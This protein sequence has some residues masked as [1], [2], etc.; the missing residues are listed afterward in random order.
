MEVTV[1]VVV[2]AEVEVKMIAAVIEV[3]AVDRFE[4]AVVK[5]RALKSNKNNKN[6]LITKEMKKKIKLIRNIRTKRSQKT[7][8][9]LKR[10]MILLLQAHLQTHLQ[11]HHQ[12]HIV[13]VLAHQEVMKNINEISHE[14]IKMHEKDQK[15]VIH[16]HPLFTILNETKRNRKE[17]KMRK[18]KHHHPQVVNN[19]NLQKISSLKLME[20]YKKS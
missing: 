4:V 15:Q 17:R 13:R 5:V 6:K 1:A 19:Q 11:V 7:Q 18:I 9:K 20:N 14:N 12:I 3:K 16:L 8:N 2:T 10:K